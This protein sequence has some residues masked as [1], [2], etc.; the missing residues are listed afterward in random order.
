MRISKIIFCIMFVFLSEAAFSIRFL[1]FSEYDFGEG[2]KGLRLVDFDIDA[3]TFK[4]IRYYKYPA[5]SG[6]LAN[7][8]GFQV[9]L[10]SAAGGGSIKISCA[11]AKEFQNFAVS[12]VETFESAFPS[13]IMEKKELRKGYEVFWK[14]REDKWIEKG[15]SILEALNLKSK[16]TTGGAA[17]EVLHLSHD[18]A[19]AG[20][21]SDTKKPFSLIVEGGG[22]IGQKKNNTERALLGELT[23]TLTMT[24]FGY[25]Q[26]YSK[27]GAEK[28]IDGVFWDASTDPELFITEAKNRSTSFSV[29]KCMKTNLAE[30]HIATALP[31]LTGAGGESK[32]KIEYFIEHTPEKIFKLA[33][34]VKDD[35]TVQCLV[36]KFDKEAYYTSI[37]DF[38]KVKKSDKLAMVIEA[39][40]SG[41]SL[42]EIF[43]AFVNVVK[44]DYK[45]EE[46]VTDDEILK[47]AFEAALIDE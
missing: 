3:Q 28:G 18:E 17:F 12:F 46:D 32:T 37:G 2:R 16:K 36:K 31:L 29:T 44:I 7:Y 15:S 23:T 41:A 25:K 6:K 4:S 20:N 33:Q 34:K 8:E 13:S 27:Y 47:E 26:Y 43:A 11:T 30:S 10:R 22:E 35:G 19:T 42:K 5:E 9:E 21:W 14:K 38:Y 39:F 45:G 40:S 1:D 24:W